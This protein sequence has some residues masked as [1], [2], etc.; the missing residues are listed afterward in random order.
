MLPPTAISSTIWH[1]KMSQVSYLWGK[2]NWMERLI[3]DKML[4]YEMFLK[5]SFEIP[6]NLCCWKHEKG[7]PKTSSAP[8]GVL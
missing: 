6:T 3:C 1:K 5:E 8:A 7:V 4:S 2:K